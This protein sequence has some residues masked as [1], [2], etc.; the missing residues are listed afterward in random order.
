MLA[1]EMLGA[2]ERQDAEAF[3]RA[4]NREAWDK[5]YLM[6]FTPLTR[7][8][9]NKFYEGV[10]KCVNQHGQNVNEMN[11]YGLAPLHCTQTLQTVLFLCENGA[12]VNLQSKYNAATPICCHEIDGEFELAKLLIDHGANPMIRDR[13]GKNAYDYMS[14]GFA[15]RVKRYV[16]EV[17]RKKTTVESTKKRTIEQR[18]AS[19]DQSQEVDTKDNRELVSDVLGLILNQIE[20]FQAIR[21]ILKRLDKRIKELEKNAKSVDAIPEGSTLQRLEEICKKAHPGLELI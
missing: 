21:A 2:I 3:S 15:D 12:D 10:V 4:F 17:E 8:C 7:C 1:V 9:D 6:R 11:R 18:E 14:K 16:E 19:K 13:E 5:E 20:G